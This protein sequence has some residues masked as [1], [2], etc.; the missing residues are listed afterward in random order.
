MTSR[1][2][3]AEATRRLLIDT[4]D[5]LVRERGYEN[6]SVEDITKASGVA[7]GTFYHHF[8]RKEDIILALSQSHLAELMSLIPTLGTDDPIISIGNYLQQFITVVQKSDVQLTRQW[9]RYIVEPVN[10]QKWANDWQ[11]IRQLLQALIENRRLSAT[12]PVD[13]LAQALMTEIYGIVL[14][15]CVSPATVQP[16]AVLK[17]FN[18]VQLAGLLTPYLL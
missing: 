11:G 7:K 8:K 16:L 5:R 13:E 14:S 2:E 9:V 6:L 1:Q 10:Q 4:A 18:Q 15:W 3:A 12:T 17:Q